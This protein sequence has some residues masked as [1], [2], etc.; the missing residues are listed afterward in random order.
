MIRNTFL[1]ILW[2]SLHLHKAF[3]VWKSGLNNAVIIGD[4][5][6]LGVE[7]LGHFCASGIGV[8]G[9]KAVRH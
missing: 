5:G 7:E 8:V 2:I 1:D 9:L 6:E 3:Y 4:I